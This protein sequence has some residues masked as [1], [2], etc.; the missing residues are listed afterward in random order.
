MINEIQFSKIV[1]NE[2]QTK[3]ISLNNKTFFGSPLKKFLRSFYDKFDIP[4]E[5]FIISMYYLNKFYLMNKDKNYNNNNNEI[6]SIESIENL[7]KETKLYVFTSI[8]IALKFILDFRINV[9]ELC[10]LIDI[11]YDNYITT[12]LIIL[13]GLNWNVFLD[14]EDFVLFKTKLEHLKD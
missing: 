8:I 11:N 5:S 13:R 9:S 2:T 1:S 14:N 4:K 6:E 10:K 7:F 3:K 12:E